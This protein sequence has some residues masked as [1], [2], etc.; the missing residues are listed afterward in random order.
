MAGQLHWNTSIL[1]ALF[2]SPTGGD[3]YSGCGF[4]FLAH[5]V[6]A[7]ITIHRLMEYLIYYHGISHSIASDWGTHFTAN[8]VHP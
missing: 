7:H 6:S 1:E 8:E 3:E 2:F 4:V 5:N